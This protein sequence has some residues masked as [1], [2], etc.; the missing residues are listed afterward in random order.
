MLRVARNFCKAEFPDL[1][2][3]F[4]RVNFELT[5][6]HNLRK[7][8][9]SQVG[10]EFELTPDEFSVFFD[11]ALE[12]LKSHIKMDG[13]RPGQVP[14]ELAEKKVGQEDLLMEAGELAVKDS[15]TKFM[16]ESN[17]EPIGQPDVQMKKIAKGSELL[18]TVTVSVLPEV[19]LPDYKKIASEVKGSE[20]SVTD[21]EIEESLNYL[22]RSRATFT[23]KPVAETKD[24][25][26]IEYQNK[27]INDGKPIKDMFILGEGGFLKDFEDNLLGMK[28]G[29]EKEFS[30]KFPSPSQVLPEG[31]ISE[32][33]NASQG[34]AGTEGQFKV[35]MLVIQKMEL[36]EINDAFAKTLGRDARSS[37]EAGDPVLGFDTVAVLK[38]NLKE[39]IGLEKK[40]GE[41]QRKRAEILNK[42]ASQMHFDLP[43]SMVEYEQKRLF[44]NLKNQVAQ[45]F[46]VPFEEYLKSVKKTEEEIQA[47][48]AKEAEKRIKEYL[49]LREIGKKENV[50]VSPKE[51]EEEANRMVKNYPKEQLQKIDIVR[52]KEYAKDTLYNEK[53]FQV[54]EKL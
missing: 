32:G 51:A 39:G 37:R 30:A 22:R 38:D 42:I 6:K 46:K 4:D 21:K 48:Y 20:V 14:K 3:L 13:F 35:K 29:D 34:L 10:I 47:S 27:D 15:Y 11:K 54:L 26:K 36:P 1:A 18:F 8:E 9:K 52:I 28:V 12:H 33:K 2:K 44:E 31:K 45:S 43:H 7:L 19:A 23:D 40:E 41:R 53:V 16:E 49:I 24:Y 25:V 17:L 5:M 50:V